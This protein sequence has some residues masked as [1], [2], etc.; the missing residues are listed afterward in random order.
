MTTSEPL[1]QDWQH[2]LDL[3]LAFARNEKHYSDA[4]VDAYQRHLVTSAHYF[5]QFV[6]SWQ[7]IEVENIKGLL[8]KLKSRNLSARTINLHLS[9]LRSFYK[10]LIRK[11]LATANPVELVKGPKFTKPLP[12]NL[13]VDQVNQLL[14]IV[15]EDTL[16]VRD[17]AMMELMY[18]SGLRLSELA[19]LNLN[20]KQAIFNGLLTVKGKGSKERVIP[21]GRKAISAVKEWLKVRAEFANADEMAL[22]TSKQKRRLSIRQ[23]RARMK[24]WGIEQGLSANVHPHKLRHSFASHILESSGDLRAVQELL[25][26]SN[27]STTQVYTH[28]DFQHLAKVYDNTHPRAKKK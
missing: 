28:L 7:A 16:A 24:K 22:F 19:S 14:E 12:K 27:L 20:D 3:F 4:T 25:G 18:S 13:D 11:G 10:F 1:N 21:V 9:C 26:H 17:K 23:I 2:T 15:P 5:S 8:A 6:N